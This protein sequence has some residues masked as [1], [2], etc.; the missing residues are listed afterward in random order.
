LLK[1]IGEEELYKLMG[2][3]DLSSNDNI[4]V[5]EELEYS[6]FHYTYLRLIIYSHFFLFYNILIHQVFGISKR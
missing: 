1:A 3:N 5:Q 2:R 6:F 4:Q